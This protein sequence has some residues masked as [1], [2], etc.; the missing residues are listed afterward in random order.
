M[1]TVSV[2][3]LMFTDG[4]ILVADSEENLHQNLSIYQ[5]VLKKINMLVNTDKTNST[6]TSNEDPRRRYL[7][8]VPCITIL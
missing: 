7:V 1:E 6:I 4:M 3:E 5:K 2:R 8:S